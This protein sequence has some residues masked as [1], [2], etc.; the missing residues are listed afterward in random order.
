M[1]IRKSPSL[2]LV[3]PL[4]VILGSRLGTAK[5][6][7]FI[8]HSFFVPVAQRFASLPA[9]SGIG[10]HRQRTVYARGAA[11]SPEALWKGPKAGS[12]KRALQ[13]GSIDLLGMT[14]HRPEDSSFEDYQRWVEFALKHNPDTDFF[15][16]LPW[17]RNGGNATA[18]QMQAMN[19]EGD[20]ILTRI[21][22]RLRGVYPNQRFY[23]LNYGK[24]AAELNRLFELGELMG[25]KRLVGAGGVYA[26]RTGHANNL[27][28]D[29][30]A[31]LWLKSIYGVSPSGSFSFPHAVDIQAIA[32]RL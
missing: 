28:K 1:K 21:V 15:I 23:Y 22:S 12:I 30:S 17:S 16:G 6:C 25:A 7:L 29:L 31:L 4:L 3:I 11:G 10:D 26:D 13:G 9:Q 18:A 8:G 20:R 19:Q 27:L 14:F 32:L 2:L 5:E 24:A